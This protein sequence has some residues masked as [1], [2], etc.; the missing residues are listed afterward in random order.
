VTLPVGRFTLDT[1]PEP[2]GSLPIK[3]TIGMVWVAAFAAS[4]AGRKSAA[5]TLT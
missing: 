3:N 4:A 5:I 2:I 1:S